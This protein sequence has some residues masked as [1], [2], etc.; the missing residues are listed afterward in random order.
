[1]KLTVLL[2]V[3]SAATLTAPL[4]IGSPSLTTLE[5][6]QTTSEVVNIF[7]AHAWENE[8]RTIGKLNNLR[9][10]RSRVKHDG[11]KMTADAEPTSSTTGEDIFAFDAWEDEK[12]KRSKLNPDSEAIFAK[13]QWDN[14][15]EETPASRRAIARDEPPAAVTS[16]DTGSSSITTGPA[17]PPIFAFDAWDA[18]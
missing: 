5:A 1:M 18:E 12:R 10:T 6:R 16:T 3:A 9:M 17:A 2:S 13:F 7:A 11:D 14:D 8:K 4:P 15:M